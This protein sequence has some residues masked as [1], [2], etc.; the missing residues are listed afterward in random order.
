VSRP[1]V[2]SVPRVAT[3]GGTKAGRAITC[4]ALHTKVGVKRDEIA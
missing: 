1:F 3:K 2:P 4:Q